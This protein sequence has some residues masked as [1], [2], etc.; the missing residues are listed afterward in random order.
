[1]GQTEEANPATTAITT[2]T[3]SVGAGAAVTEDS[4]D[5][6]RVTE[7]VTVTVAVTVVAI[8]TATIDAQTMAGTT[9]TFVRIWRSQCISNES[10]D[11]R[12]AVA[13]AAASAVLGNNTRNARDHEAGPAHVAGP[14]A[15]TV[16]MTAQSQHSKPS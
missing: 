6:T 10:T 1:M 5:T 9:N 15:I 3:K 2:G 11:L 7:D 8:A 16:V 12:E 4:V 14:D 13:V